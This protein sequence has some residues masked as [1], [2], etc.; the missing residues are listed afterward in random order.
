MKKRMSIFFVLAMFIIMSTTSA[1][2]LYYKRMAS[3]QIF[4]ARVI[5]TSHHKP[6]ISLEVEDYN[7]PD[8]V[9]P[10]LSGAVYGDTDWTQPPHDDNGNV[11]VQG[12][13]VTITTNEDI[14]D[15]RLYLEA[16]GD[17]SAIGSVNLG[18]NYLC[19]DQDGQ[20]IDG[21]SGFMDCTANEGPWS[22]YVP[23]GDLPA[24]STVVVYPSIFLYSEED[25]YDFEEGEVNIT[26]VVATP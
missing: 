18:I 2:A 26:L 15:V 4:S 8:I 16:E 19:Y 22:D 20:Q 17:E 1:T 24:D 21:S 10:V 3:A 11:A 14:S 12:P 23:L 9:L 5:S 6:S 25:E 7:N 13:T